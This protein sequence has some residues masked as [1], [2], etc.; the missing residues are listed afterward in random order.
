MG[1]KDLALAAGGKQHWV[2]WMI[3]VDTCELKKRRQL[4]VHRRLAVDSDRVLLSAV[5]CDVLSV[6]ATCRE[7]HVKMWA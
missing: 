7:M 5:N 1:V 2:S 6:A 4:I 3:Y